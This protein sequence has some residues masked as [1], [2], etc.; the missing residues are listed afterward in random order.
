MIKRTTRKHI[1]NLLEN[2]SDWNILDLGCGA[3]G[4]ETAN[5]L[6]D[7]KDHSDLYPDKRFVCCDASKT[8]FEEQEFD[9]VIANHITEHIVD[10]ELFLNELVRI[11]KRG[12]IEVPTPLF[13]NLVYGNRPP[14]HLWWI[15]FDDIEGQLI[16]TPK[17]EVVG[18][19]IY[20]IELKTLDS[21]FRNSMVTELYWETSIERKYGNRI[22]TYEN[23]LYDFGIKNIPALDFWPSDKPIT[24]TDICQ[25]RDIE[26]QYSMSVPKRNN[27][28]PEN[29]S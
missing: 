27:K 1:Q 4:W 14:E 28:I 7:Q 10:M 12:Y 2:N 8:P 23:G 11:S 20:P 13:D 21:F 16:C 5:T 3:Y 9:F 18:E 24:T 29:N 19:Q 6:L 15:T 17:I 22:F 26:G 25:L